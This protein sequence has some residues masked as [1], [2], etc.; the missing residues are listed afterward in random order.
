MKTQ[1]KAC[2]CDLMDLE[3][4]QGATDCEECAALQRDFQR[5][6]EALATDAALASAGVSRG[7]SREDDALFLAHFRERLR[8]SVSAS[9]DLWRWLAF[10]LWPVSAGLLLGAF[11]ALGDRADDTTVDL[12][13]MTLAFESTQS[14]IEPDVLGDFLAPA[15]ERSESETEPLPEPVQSPEHD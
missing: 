15:L 3:A 13:G 7:W 9:E 5:I 11:L 8:S 1:C 12:E 4:V 6:S 14:G 2:G 10:R